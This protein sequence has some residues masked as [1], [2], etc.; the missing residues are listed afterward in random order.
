MKFVFNPP[1]ASHFGGVFES[2]IKSGKRAIRAILKNRSVTDLE[3]VTIFCEAENILNSRPLALQNDDQN[4]FRP[5]TPAMFLTGRLSG[6]IFPPNID[7]ND[8][9]HRKRWRYV[10][11]AS[12][13]IWKRWQKE[14]LPTL[15]PRSKWFKDNPREYQVGDEVLIME[16]D[17][18]RYKWRTARISH[19]Y[20]GRDGRIRVVDCSTAEGSMQTPVH[21]LIPLT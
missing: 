15:G 18:P 12:A 10:Q 13:D 2:I 20:P 16:K 14:I 6:M 4:D 5:L 19:V 1:Y 7:L 8:F 11:Q 9:D 21:R 17:L 3:L